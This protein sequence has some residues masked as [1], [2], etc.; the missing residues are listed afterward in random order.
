MTESAIAKD[1]EATNVWPSDQYLDETELTIVDENG[2]G[3]RRPL[4]RSVG[5]VPVESSDRDRTFKVPNIN[6]PTETRQLT[7]LAAGHFIELSRWDGTVL[8]VTSTSFWARLSDP[9]QSRGEEEAEF[10]V[11][12]IASFDRPLLCPGAAFYW[13][14]GYWD[15]ISGMR[16]RISQIRFRRLPAWSASELERVKME[17][18]ALAKLFE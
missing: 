8:E 17:A 7:V 2:A 13:S 16:S 10:A 4:S 18:K 1:S 15:S 11:D 9:K 5:S 14:I 6:V 12:E 3:V